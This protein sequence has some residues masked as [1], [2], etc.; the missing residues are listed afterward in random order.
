M[1]FEAEVSR[2]VEVVLGDEE[3][4]R[5]EWGSLADALRRCLPAVVAGAFQRVVE[6]LDA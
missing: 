6:R 2:D 5:F 4:D 3:H 1:V